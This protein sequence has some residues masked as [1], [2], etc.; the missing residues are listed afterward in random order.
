MDNQTTIT[1]SDTKKREQNTDTNQVKYRECSIQDQKIINQI[2]THY[3]TD[4]TQKTIRD[5]QH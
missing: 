3:T 5:T 2:Q 4:T 1:Y